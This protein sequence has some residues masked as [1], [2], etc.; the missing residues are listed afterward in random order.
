MRLTSVDEIL[1]FAIRREADDAA[2]YRWASDRSKPGVKEAFLDLAREEEEHRRKLETLDLHKLDQIEVKQ[3]QGLGIGES[4]EEVQFDSEMTYADL[5]RMAI[6]NEEKAQKL[7]S[8]TA[9]IVGDPTVKKLLLV[10]AQEEGAHKEK[11]ERRYDEDIL[12][13]F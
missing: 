2:F 8:A 11:L 13:E 10:L 6:K 4:I 3:S 5:L 7:Y 9:Q 12:K 1:R